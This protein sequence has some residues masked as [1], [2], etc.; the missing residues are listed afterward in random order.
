MKLLQKFHY[1]FKSTINK[2][3]ENFSF[4]FYFSIENKSYY[5][6]KFVLG[7]E[8]LNK[9]LNRYSEIH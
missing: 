7:L 8:S 2:E 5:N 4:V 3:Y 6:A 9:N 1:S